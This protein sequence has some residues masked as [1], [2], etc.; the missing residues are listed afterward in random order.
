M[1]LYL[2]C[3]CVLTYVTFNKPSKWNETCGIGQLLDTTVRQM[4]K[5]LNPYTEWLQSHVWPSIHVCWCPCV[6]VPLWVCVCVGAC[7]CLYL[8]M[9]VLQS[10]CQDCTVYWSH[11]IIN[12]YRS[13]LGSGDHLVD[14]RLPHPHLS[15][16]LSLSGALLGK[17]LIG[18]KRKQRQI[19][20]WMERQIDESCLIWL[21]DSMDRWRLAG[22]LVVWLLQWHTDSQDGCPAD[23]WG[24]LVIL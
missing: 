9:C 20:G 4:N 24:S 6:N 2:I 16:A 10:L 18:G 23:W 15:L 13:S 7:L 21:T 5:G 1:F 19:G 11:P 12:T 3:N 14:V 8:C 17:L 22:W